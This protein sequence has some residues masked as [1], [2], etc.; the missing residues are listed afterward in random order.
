MIPGPSWTSLHSRS[1][2]RISR[3]LGINKTC[4]DLRPPGRFVGCRVALVFARV[5]AR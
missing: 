4:Q 1:Y 5:N 3:G 2:T